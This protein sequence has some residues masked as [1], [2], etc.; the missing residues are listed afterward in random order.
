MKK[1]FLFGAML[2]AFTGESAA[3]APGDWKSALPA[4]LAR[5][6]RADCQA[7]QLGGQLRITCS[8]R[9][10]HL[11]GELRVLAGPTDDVGV[12]MASNWIRTTFPVRRGDRRVILIAAE[13]VVSAVWLDG[14]AAPTVVID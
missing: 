2:L 9:Y 1:S 13:I 3:E 4:Q 7:Q 8:S 14:E 11:R 5:N 10:D 6:A 12:V